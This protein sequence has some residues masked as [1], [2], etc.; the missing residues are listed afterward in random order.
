M[1]IIKSAKKAIRSSARKRT[2]NIRRKKTLSEV[3]K[4]FKKLVE[5][6]KLEEAKKLIPNVY[7]AFDKAA[8]T[9]VIK[10]NT[11]S[12]KKSRLAALLAKKTA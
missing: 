1:A 4:N 7:Q 8:K 9:G 12:R 5:A 2:F 11:A 10:A 3:V 6:K